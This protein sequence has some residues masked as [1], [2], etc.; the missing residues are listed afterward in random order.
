MLTLSTFGL[1]TR[2]DLPRVSYATALD[3]FTIMCFLFVVF[4]LLEFA[5]VHY[6]TKIGSGEVPVIEIDE[7]WA[8]DSQSQVVTRRCPV[9][10]T[11]S[12]ES[13]QDECSEDNYD[14]NLSNDE[15]SDKGL[16]FWKIPRCLLQFWYCLTV[17]EEYK[18]QMKKRRKRG[19]GIVNSVSL[20]DKTSRI[21][22][23]LVFILLNAFYW[24]FYWMERK[25]E[26]K[27]WHDDKI[28][29]INE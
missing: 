24:V 23:P 6:F 13:S 9:H 8:N 7:D 5:G 11:S 10:G 14:P 15:S 3:W 16:W 21:M 25:S 17:S 28:Y 26:F 4:T 1:D 2:T 12:Q 19:Q 27:L 20:I 18:E 29:H 22:F